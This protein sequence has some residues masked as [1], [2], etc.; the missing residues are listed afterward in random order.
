[1]S[2]EQCRGEHLD[3]RSDIYSLGV[4]AYQMLSGVPPFEGDF[5]AVMEAHST[6]DPPPLSVKK[7]RR[8]LKRVIHT[9][10]AK[11]PDER[12]ESAEA[13]ASELR[14]RSEGIFDLF[15]R[16]MVIYSEHLPKFLLLTGFFSIPMAVL[17]LIWLVF[18]FL[19]INEILSTN[20]AN[21]MLGVTSF[22]LSIATAFCTNLIVGT[23]AWIVTQHLAV[24][25]RP[26]RLRPAMKEARKKWK[27]MAGAGVFTALLPFVSSAAGGL[28]GFMIFA[29]FFGAFYPLTGSWEAILI[30]GGGGAVLTGFA[31]F[32]IAHMFWVLVPPVIVMENAGIAES[33]KRSVRLV[34][35]SISTSAGTVI[36]KFMIP[37][38]V[39]GTISYIVNISA[40]AFDPTDATKVEKTEGQSTSESVTPP[41]PPAEPEEKSEGGINFS[42]GKPNAKVE[43]ADDSTMRTKV[44]NT[45]LE[46]L[47]QILWLPMQILVFSFS[48]IIVALLYLKTR[49]AGGE[50]MNDLI[51][52]F[53]DD[54]RPRKKWQERVR[55]RL[56]QS[57]RLPSKP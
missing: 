2:P 3:P 30:G 48:G 10:L 47:I 36:I 6:A 20:V 29:L 5:K 9:A 16:G 41:V 15:R 32:F 44:K 42:F 50:S 52:R 35:R 14:A 40:K 45:I 1:M 22:G 28:L 18:A 39:V 24:P 34:R 54:G 46:S 19:K 17:T 26:I 11:D 12:P 43:I 23:I 49:L 37:L 4:I 25:L 13:F 31:A 27:R 38:I 55:K 56:I 33:L 21:V 8:K 57:G 53:E 7:V 51:E